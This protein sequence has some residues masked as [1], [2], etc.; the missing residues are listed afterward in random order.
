MT[1]PTKIKKL[2]VKSIV[3]FPCFVSNS[4]CR[5]NLLWRIMAF[6]LPFWSVSLFFT[7]ITIGYLLAHKFLILYMVLGT[8]FGH[9]LTCY[10]EKEEKQN[11]GGESFFSLNQSELT[12]IYEQ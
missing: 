4:K 11:I 3:V 5:K 6:V 8:T 2:Y 1:D 12:N 10:L 7:P 9:M